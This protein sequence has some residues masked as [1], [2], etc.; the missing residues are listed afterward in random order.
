MWPRSPCLTSAPCT[1]PSKAAQRTISGLAFGTSAQAAVP[2]GSG[3]VERKSARPVSN[4]CTRWI[5]SGVSD[6][7]RQG[8]VRRM[9]DISIA[10]DAMEDVDGLERHPILQ[11]PYV[12]LL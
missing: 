11:E 7:H 1:S 10:G 4:T 3:P 2:A 12:L 5:L 8:L 9:L 6:A